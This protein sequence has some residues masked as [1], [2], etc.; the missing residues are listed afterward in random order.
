MTQAMENFLI[1]GG[2]KYKRIKQW[3]KVLESTY[4]RKKVKRRE[5]EE[6]T[7]K[8]LI[9]LVEVHA[10]CTEHHGY[11]KIE[12]E[13]VAIHVGSL[14]LVLWLFQYWYISHCPTVGNSIVGSN[15]CSSIGW[16]LA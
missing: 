16:E 9:S 14:Q 7:W 12:K 2:L 13:E 10:S 5:K 6:R 3:N 11:K 8:K 15:V 1:A 4:K